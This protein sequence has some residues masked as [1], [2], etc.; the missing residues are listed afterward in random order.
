MKLPDNLLFTGDGPL[1]AEPGTRPADKACAV[2]GLLRAN[3]LDSDEGVAGTTAE[4]TE[5][6]AY[7]IVVLTARERR[8]KILEPGPLEPVRGGGGGKVTKSGES[9]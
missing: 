8:A 4:F 5:A 9:W 1:E 7:G 2:V 3:G 6:A